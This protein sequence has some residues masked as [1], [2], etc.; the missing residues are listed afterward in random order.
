MGLEP[1]AD[2]MAGCKK[3]EIHDTYGFFD[4]NG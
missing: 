1:I 3:S 4:L 2:Y